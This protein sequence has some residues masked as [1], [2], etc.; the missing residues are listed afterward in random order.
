M[1]AAARRA[2]L[3]VGV[4]T[5]FAAT[6]AVTDALAG[7]AAPAETREAPRRVVHVVIAGED[8][9]AAAAL[10]ASLREL[11]ARIDL[12]VEASRAERVDLDAST[13]ADGGSEL[14]T[15]WVDLR[16]TRAATAIV[17]GRTGRVVA[18]RSVER[19]RSMAIV[20]E[21]LAHII[22][23]SVEELAEQERH[24]AAPPPAS[25]AP[26]PQPEPPKPEPPRVAEA[27]GRLGVDGGA[28]FAGRSFG[29][30][31]EAVVG[32]GGMVGAALG[33][34]PFRPALWLIGTYH[35]AF[36]VRGRAVDVHTKAATLRLAPA[37][38]VVGGAKWLIEAGPQGGFDVMWTTPRANSSGLPT[39]RLGAETTD[40][41]PVV[42]AFVMAHFSV[43][44]S[45]DLVVAL[46][47]DVDLSPHRFVIAEGRETEALFTPWRVR[48]ALL[49]GFT[50]NL[51]GSLP[52]PAA[53]APP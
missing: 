10:E 27:P 36:D 41:S 2:A 18:R 45:A 49:L 24:R 4:L 26:A 8:A 46:S 17:E 50:F 16:A 32:G 40:A 28:F 13:L 7:D 11:V 35:V 29:S 1:N 25:P 3:W 43:G 6:F 52:Y 33:R 44:P 20:V 34:G 37:I 48:P 30:G 53:G 15:A 14:A 19:D 38:R 12:T 42:G 51:A 9:E 23:A 47:A 39:E 21:E 5:A 31:A 22:Q